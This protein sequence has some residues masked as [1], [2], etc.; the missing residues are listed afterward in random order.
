MNRPDLGSRDHKLEESVQRR[1]QRMKRAESERR[2][3][4]GESVCRSLRVL[5]LASG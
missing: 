5:I 3:L 4:V 2:T 1:V